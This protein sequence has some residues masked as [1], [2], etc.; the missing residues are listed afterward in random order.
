MQ[1][2]DEK[3]QTGASTAEGPSGMKCFQ[4][5]TNCAC[6]IEICKFLPCVASRFVTVVSTNRRLIDLDP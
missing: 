1:Q 6:N 4:S 5:S 2:Y 3:A